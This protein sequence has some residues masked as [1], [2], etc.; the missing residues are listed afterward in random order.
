[1]II[2]TGFH[3]LRAALLLPFLAWMLLSGTALAQSVYR[4]G[5]TYSQ[6][7]CPQGKPVNV[8]DPRNP[9]QVQ[10]A[11]AQ[12]ARDQDLADQ[13]HRE[14]AERE[15]ARRKVLKQEALLAR[16]NALAQQR[17]WLRQER[18]RRAAR[19]HDTRKVVS[20]SPAS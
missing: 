7:P 20:G 18:A 4:C 12:T 2:V 19:Q 6:A 16:K 1:M 5:S 17:A 8:V 13:L 11:L 9:A 14:N 10:Q 3:L 15:A